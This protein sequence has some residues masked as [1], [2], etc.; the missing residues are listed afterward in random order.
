[1]RQD[2]S[3]AISPTR[4]GIRAVRQDP[5]HDEPE[6]VQEVEPLRNLYEAI[7]AQGDATNPRVQPSGKRG[8]TKQSKPATMLIR[9]REHADDV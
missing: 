7:L 6:Y 9:P 3:G 1:M 8:R 2:P 4:S 5:G